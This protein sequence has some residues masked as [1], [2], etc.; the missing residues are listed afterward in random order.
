MRPLLI[1]AAALATACTHVGT[2]TTVRAERGTAVRA[3]DQQILSEAVDAAFAAL[4]VPRVRRPD[5]AATPRV[6]PLSAYVHVSTV[7]PLSD[8]LRDYVGTRASA[9]A[10]GAGLTVREVRRVIERGN[11]VERSFLEYPD[12]EARVLVAVSYAGVDQI[13]ATG[14]YRS[15]DRSQLTLAG[16]FKATVSIVPRNTDVPVWSG[17]IAGEKKLAIDEVEYWHG[18]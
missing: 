10:A 12:T 6:G 14:K 9:V 3:I 13:D 2:K 4:E 17:T 1:A 18:R 15:T 16:R 5:G 7:M 11:G 8:E